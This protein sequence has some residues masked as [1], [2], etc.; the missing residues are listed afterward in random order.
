MEDLPQITDTIR[1]PVHIDIHPYLLDHHVEGKGVLPAVEA[2]NLL[3]ET[4]KRFRPETDITDMT[5]ARFDKFLYIQPDMTQL[6]AYVDIE[7]HENGDITAKLLTKNRSKKSSITRTKLHASVC[8][9]KKKID[10][11]DLPLDLSS[12]LEGICV[13]IPPDKIYRELVPFGPAY[14]NIQDALYISE[15]GAIAKAGSPK[16]KAPPDQPAQLGSP[17]PL[18]AAFH[19]ACVWGQRYGQTV[20]FPVGF[21]RRTVFNSTRSGEIYF[22]HILPLQTN[23]TPFLFDMRIYDKDGNLYEEVRGVQ[24]RDVSAGRVKPPAWISKIEQ[25]NPLECI[26]LNCRATSVIELKTLMP[27]SEKILS[28]HERK[29]FQQM[30]EKQKRSYLGARLA[31]KRLSRILS[32]N[33]MLTLP[34]KIT[35]ADPDLERPCCPLTNGDS[36]L[37]CSVSHDDRFAIAVASDQRVGVDVEKT[38]GRVMKSSS[39]FMRKNEQTLVRASPLGE[40]DA[41]VRIWSIKEAAAK[42]LDFTI[43]DSWNRVHV[44]DVGQ[45]KSTIGIDG[46]DIYS[47]IHERVDRHLFTLVY[48][49][50]SSR[51]HHAEKP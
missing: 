10:F 50:A 34:S 2:M 8:Y 44:M 27:F 42:A 5:E 39:L 18:D 14:H 46:M 26:K 22:M 48:R 35:T 20:A 17:F 51:I 15:Y 6:T 30:G 24:M 16:R 3:G 45:C 31:C 36:A 28:V 47:A 23:S 4:V 1:L 19:A 11:A 38:S 43:A 7:R 32:G 21:S 9:P 13:E 25:K 33:D 12:A 49:S 29:H 37:P 41:A 40:I